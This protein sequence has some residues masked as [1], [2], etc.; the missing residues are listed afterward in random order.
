VRKPAD[1]LQL[2][3]HPT[4]KMS[5]SSAPR[6]F[7]PSS[8]ASSRAKEQQLQLPISVSPE[9]MIP[10]L[11]QNTKNIRNICIVAHVDHGKTTLCDNLVATA[12]VISERSAGRLRYMDSRSDEQEREITMKSSAIS[13]GWRDRERHRE[14]AAA[15]AEAGGEKPTTEK[16]T[17]PKSP[18][19]V[20]IT[21]SDHL[22]NLIDSPGHVDFSAEVSAATRLADGA[23]VVVDVVEGISAQTREVLRQAWH[24]RLRTILVLNKVD[25]LFI[26]LELTPDEAYVHISNVIGE[27]NAAAQELLTEAAIMR[28]KNAEEE[29]EKEKE[30]NK[31]GSGEKKSAASSATTEDTGVAVDADVAEHLLQ[32]DDEKE[33]QWTYHPSKGNVVF[34]SAV[35][36]WGF[37]IQSFAKFVSKK[38]GASEKVLQKTLWGDYCYN[39]KQKKV[40]AIKGGMLAGEGTYVIWYLSLS[41]SH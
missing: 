41:I 36:G 16:P 1:S 18:N 17:A 3:L 37:S 34:C 14:R 10:T 8:R 32:F 7:S 5:Q 33:A 21:E 30:K 29:R 15:K 25:R 35:H 4:S 24:D 28:D 20:E 31:S 40:M 27:A 26:N 23:L 39:V 38:I 11:Q 19:T 13:L 6:S 2:N 12:G 22:I 9:N